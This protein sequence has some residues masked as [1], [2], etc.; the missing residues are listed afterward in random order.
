MSAILVQ[1]V[2]KSF[3]KHQVL[4][5][6]SLSC[7]KGNIY[8]I[9]GYNG[10]GKSVLFKC[11]CGFTK[12]DKGSILINDQPIKDISIFNLGIIIETPAYISGL[13]G[14]DNLSYLYRIKNKSN[15]K[16]LEEVMQ[17]V[18]LNPHSKK[19]VGK[20]SLGM[21]QRLAIAQAIMED[22]IIGKS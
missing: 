4:N 12:L 6:V 16:H 15:K 19:G 18:G 2:S 20:Y 22:H 7:D 10:S 14:I 3:G 1:N 17:Q 13:S 9:V 21:K 5:N 11:I 8:G